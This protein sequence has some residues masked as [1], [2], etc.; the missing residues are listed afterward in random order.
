MPYEELSTFFTDLNKV[1]KKKL[2]GGDSQ[3]V[4]LFCAYVTPLLRYLRTDLKNIY[5]YFLIGYTSEWVP[6]EL[7][8][9]IP[10]LKVAHKRRFK[11][12]FFYFFVVL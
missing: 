1:D 10:L 9:N 7:K 8:E 2:K 5:L 4:L 11:V 3:Y 12:V 6:F